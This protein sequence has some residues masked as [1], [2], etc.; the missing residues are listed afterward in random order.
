MYKMNNRG[1][2]MDPCG[3]PQ[4]TVSKS[5]FLPKHFAACTLLDKYVLKHVMKCRLKLKVL[6]FFNSILWSTVSRAFFRSRNTTPVIYIVH[7]IFLGGIES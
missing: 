4:V 5:D 2:K 1:P 7:L 3:T 6:K